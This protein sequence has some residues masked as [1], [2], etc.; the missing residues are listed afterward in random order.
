MTYEAESVGEPIQSAILL[1]D[2]RR[3]ELDVSTLLFL[4]TENPE[5]LSL[6][7][8]LSLLPEVGQVVR[9]VKLGHIVYLVLSLVD[10]SFEVVVQVL[11][12]VYHLVSP[13]LLNELLHRSI[14]L[15]DLLLS[16][17]QGVTD[18]D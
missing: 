14:S 5:L 8:L 17:F 18:D 1:Q 15:S 7:L 10:V 12:S 9:V 13:I 16:L 11:H 2:Q 3:L 4:L 6:L